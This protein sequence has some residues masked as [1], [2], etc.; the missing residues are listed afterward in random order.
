MKRLAM[1]MRVAG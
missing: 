1:D